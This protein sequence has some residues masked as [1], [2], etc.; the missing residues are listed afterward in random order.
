SKLLSSLASISL[1]HFLET[2]SDFM[3]TPSRRDHPRA[4]ARRNRGGCP[5]SSG[6]VG[7]WSFNLASENLFALGS[8]DAIRRAAYRTADGQLRFLPL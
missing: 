4:T 2:A 3:K 8:T 5:A 1:F 6:S 7:R